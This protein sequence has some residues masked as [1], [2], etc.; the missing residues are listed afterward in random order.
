MGSGGQVVELP[1]PSVV[2]GSSPSS[3]QFNRDF[4]RTGRYKTVYVLL[5]YGATA[6][7]HSGTNENGAG[8]GI[9]TL[10]FDLGKVALY[11]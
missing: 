6:L 7:R 1:A 9:R 3:I 2:E 8:E 10:D 4:Y 11:R 5:N